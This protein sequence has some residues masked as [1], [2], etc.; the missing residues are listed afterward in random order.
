MDSAARELRHAARR[1][2]RAPAFASAAVLTLALAIGANASIFAV[3]KRVVLNPLPYP[4]SDQLIE[5]DHGAQV[6]KVAAGMGVA[7]GLYFHYRNRSRT[8]ISLALYRT[9]DQTITGDGEPQRI[10]V[11][12]ATPSLAAVLQVAPA[13]GRWFSEEEGRPGAAPVAVL[14]HSLWMRRYG[15]A[16]DVIGGVMR[17]GGE[18][19]EIVGVMPASF[20]FPDPRVEAWTTEQLDPAAGFGLW[21]HSGIARLRDGVTLAAARSELLGLIGDVAHA[22]PNDPFA[23]GNVETRLFFSGRT[24][25]DATVGAVARPLWMLLASVGLVLL[26]GCANVA[27][28]FLVRSESRQ[29]ELA[30]R[31]AL[32]AS[33]GRIARYFLCESLLLS[34]AGGTAGLGLAWG[35]VRL[36][37][38]FAPASLPRLAE[39]QLDTTALAFTFALSTLTAIAFG[40]LPLWRADFAPA[41][42]HESGRGNTITQRRQR[43]RHL[44]MAAQVAFA[45]VLVIASGLMLR[46][47]QHLRAVDPG[48]DASSA[49]TF[50]IGLPPRAYATRDS[51]AAAHQ[52]IIDALTPLPGVTGVA[53]TTCLPLA[54][55]CSG[56]TVRIE[57]SPLERNAAPPP[58]ALW[59]AV[60]GQYFQT[61]GTR[62]VRGRVID[63]H[64]IDRHEPIAVVNEAFVRT[65]FAGDDPIGRRVASNRP[66]PKPG[67]A[68]ELTWLTVVG[69]VADT[70]VRTL[71]ETAAPQLY[72]PLSIASGPEMPRAALIGPEISVMSY[73]IRTVTAPLDVLPVVRRVIHGLDANLAVAQGETLE[74]RLDRASAQTAFTM[75]LLAVAATVALLL[76]TVGI[77]GVT[78]YIV[79]QRTGEIGVRLALGALP[80]SLAAQILRQGGVV[81]AAGIAVGLAAAL[82]GARLLE[83]LLYAVSPRD[84]GVFSLT[85]ATLLAVALL[86]CWIPARRAARLNPVD[87]LRTE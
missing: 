28:L 4:D 24:L 9:A 25:K 86:A 62:L 48:F 52:A 32:G 49:L 36:V 44:L 5:L 1:L 21:G 61:I 53:A 30:V 77:Y 51:V 76:G 31:R 8:L 13:R 18:A 6:L 46:T 39:I 87:A 85:A 82:A 34:L 11:A 33:R 47:L 81:A 45:T 69:I 78:S 60:S 19:M 58:L 3:V 83:S 16:R 75:I 17:L 20:A 38:W 37:V 22:Y 12:R 54:G 50:S 65:F 23:A 84:P 74:A 73:V 7:P 64:D 42:L 67:A 41:A 26:V 15:G 63:R 66:P 40:L 2:A 79:S 70:P 56:N 57:G 10:R 27:N 71:T 14:S 35:A 55:G 43:A 72:L 59:R 68:P 29:R 80:A